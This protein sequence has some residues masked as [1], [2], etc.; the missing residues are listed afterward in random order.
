[1]SGCTIV[2][3][4]YNEAERLRADLFRDFAHQAQDVRF[5]MVDDGST[6]GTL[7]LLRELEQADGQHFAVYRLPSNQGKAEAVRQGML[8]ALEEHPAMV[9][10]WDA[11]LATPLEAI[12]EFCD[13]LMERA[14]VMMVI[15][16]RV[17]MLGRRIDRRPLRHYLGRVF[18]TA[19]SLVIGLPVYDT[20]CGAKLF[21]AGE[22]LRELL[23]RPF[24]SR[25]I[26]DVELILRLARTTAAATAVPASE[27]IYE[28]PLKQWRDI[29]GSKL[30]PRDFLRAFLDLV[31][32]AWQYRQTGR[33][34]SPAAPG[35]VESASPL[36]TAPQRN[37][38]A[39]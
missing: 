5:L 1:M 28:L 33:A 19:A 30:R 36:S 22:E 29:A 8:R 4:C 6:D 23:A 34:P 37:R 27:R 31:R 12:P 15:G 16:A 26:F 20:Q 25:W 7:D 38:R 13:L 14:E 10:F 3:P 39:A 35:P 17:L 11:D 24:C 32:I 9:G 2:I 18:A 21:R